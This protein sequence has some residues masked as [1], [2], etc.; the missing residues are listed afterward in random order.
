MPLVIFAGVLTLNFF[1]GSIWNGI[2]VVVILGVLV[3]PMIL[4]TNYTITD[5]LTLRVK[6]GLFVNMVIDIDSIR[7]IEFTRSVLSSP[8]L[9]MDRIEIFYN[10]FDSVIVSPDNKM[11]FIA[12][13]QSINPAIE[14]KNPAK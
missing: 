4:N 9:S 8:A 6:C 11:E 1:I 2:L 13:L 5:N 10:K 7:K 14:I 12:K 3:I